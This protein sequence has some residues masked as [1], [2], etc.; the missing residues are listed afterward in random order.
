[1]QIPL[2]LGAKHGSHGMAWSMI[3]GD[4]SFGIE[5][6]N[7][8][9]SSLPAKRKYVYYYCRY[10]NPRVCLQLGQAEDLCVRR[11]GSRWNQFPGVDQ[12][13]QQL[14][15]EASRCELRLAN[16]VSTVL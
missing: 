16:R 15:G 11:A 12:Q 1:M 3:R 2:L 6:A 5:I 9:I 13:L 8:G 14:G 7:L 4:G 10:R